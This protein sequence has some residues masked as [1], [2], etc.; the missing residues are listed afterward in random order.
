MSNE[1]RGGWRCPTCGHALDKEAVEV[2]SLCEPGTLLFCVA[3]AA[4]LIVSED[5]TLRKLRDE[6]VTAMYVADYQRV[7]RLVN[8][9]RELRKAIEAK[10]LAS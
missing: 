3:C 2:L 5:Y 6:E 10:G 8:R 7:V 1:G 9:Q 4:L